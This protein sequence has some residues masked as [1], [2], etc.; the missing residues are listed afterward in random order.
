MGEIKDDREQR[1]QLAAHLETGRR[2]KADMECHL[3]H[4][5]GNFARECLTNATEGRSGNGQL[6]PSQ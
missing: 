1:K 5:K 2:R 3:C 6:P 4:Q